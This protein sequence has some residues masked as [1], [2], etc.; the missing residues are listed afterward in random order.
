MKVTGISPD[1]II[2][3]ANS[4]GHIRAF[5]LRMHDGRYDCWRFVLKPTDATYALRDKF[6][7]RY[8]D[9]VNW[10]GHRDFF[11]KLFEL[12]PGAIV[13]TAWATYDGVED[14]EA[15]CHESAKRVLPIG[16]T[17]LDVA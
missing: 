6:A 16:G 14:F 13:E 3:A 7:N 8:L 1:R 17:P 2:R 4:T 5:Q 10:Y 15:N 9:R 12:E 11:R